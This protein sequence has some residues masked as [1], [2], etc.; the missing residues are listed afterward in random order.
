MNW[1]RLGKKGTRITNTAAAAV[2]T[3]KKAGIFLKKPTRIALLG[4][5]SLTLIVAHTFGVYQKTNVRE[6]LEGVNALAFAD[7]FDWDELSS[8][9]LATK[10]NATAILVGIF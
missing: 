8:R 4:R 5:S 6:K 9:K 10:R 7:L 1:T 3:K 2:Y